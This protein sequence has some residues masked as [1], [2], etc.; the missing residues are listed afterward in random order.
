MTTLQRL[1]DVSPLES[2]DHDESSATIW[3]GPQEKA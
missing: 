2:L 3:W 1:A